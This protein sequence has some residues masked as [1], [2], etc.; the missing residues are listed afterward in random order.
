VAGEMVSLPAVE[1]ALLERCPKMDKVPLAVE[2]KEGTGKPVIVLFTV[3]PIEKNE[4]N[5]YIRE[6]GFSPIHY[7]ER[8]VQVEE[9]PLL[10]SGKTDYRKLKSMI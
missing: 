1:E 7:V 8:V 6:A 10:G 5:R 4:A 9:I 2:A 3:F